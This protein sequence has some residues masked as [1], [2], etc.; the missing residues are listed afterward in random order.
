M[1]PTW[2]A[3]AYSQGIF[4]GDIL[5]GE[6]ATCGESL[7]ALFAFVLMV[8][9]TGVLLGG[10]AKANGIASFTGV[11]LRGVSGSTFNMS[12]SAHTQYRDL[13]PLAQVGCNLDQAT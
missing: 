6:H 9:A 10:F 1:L 11:R 3:I 5:L 13:A 4:R 7:R 8:Q 2:A 12:Y